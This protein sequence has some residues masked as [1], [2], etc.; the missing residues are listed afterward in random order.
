MKKGI[1]KTISLITVLTLIFQML[2]PIIPELN[3]EVLAAN[4]TSEN[5]EEISRN[6]EIKEEET[7]DISANGDG[8]IIAKWTRENR[9]LTISGTGKM[10]DWDINV[11]EDWHNTQYTKAIENVII[12]DGVTNIGKYAFYGC[13][14]LKS[15][16]IPEGVTSI[17]GSAFWGCSS[18][19]SINIP[20][21][22]TSIEWQAFR[23]C[24]SLESINIPEGVTSIG[25][26]AFYECSSLESINI[27]EGVTHI[28]YDAFFKCSKLEN[29]NV[30]SD[31]KSYISV[32]GILFNKEKTKLIKYPA[33]KN[34]VKEYIIPNTV[35]EIY[36]YAFEECSSL[37]SI[38]I[39]ERV[40]S[41]EECAFYKCNN[42]ESIN[43]PEGVTSIEGSAFYGCSSLESIKIPEGVISIEGSAFSR[44][45]SLE[46]INIPEG[47]TSIEG[48]AFYGCDSLK[49]INIPE[50]V[51]SIGSDAI[52][53]STIIYVKAD[54][55][56][57]RWVEEN[58]Q[59]YILNGD[60]V[61]I[62]TNYEIKEEEM[63]DI[64]ENGDGSVIAKWT[65]KDRTLTISGTGKIR[66]WDSSSKEDWHN[67]Q[68]TN[69]IESVVICEGITN[70]GDYAFDQCSNLKNIEIA[71]DVTRIGYVVF[72]GCSSL[73][74][75][76]IPEGVTSIEGY[77]F[78][79]CDSLKSINIPESITRIGSEAFSGCSKLENI[80][81]PEGL[82]EIDRSAFSWCDSLKNIKIPEEVMYIGGSPFRGCSSLENIDVQDGNKNY[83]SENGVLF[84]KERT[85][86]ICYPMGKKNIKEY[87][88]PEG[89]TSI[90]E[91]AFFGC[92]DLESINIPKGI[93]SIGESAFWRC[94]SLKSINIPKEVTSIEWQA[95]RGCSGLESINIPEG[96]T[97]IGNYAFYECSSLESI[98]I[99]EGVT[100]IGNYAFY[101]CSSLESINIPEGIT[102]IGSNAITSKA[103]IYTK[104]NK[105]AHRYAEESK[106]GYIIDDTGPT[107]TITPNSGENV[108]REYIAKVEVQ[109]DLKEVGVN[110]S[111]L[112]YQ[113]TQSE[114][115]PAKESFTES[116]ENGQ[117]ITKNTGDGK[118]YLWVYAEDNLGNETITRS[119]EFNF[120]NT[121]PNVNVEYSTKNPTKE[122]VK[123]TITSNEEVQELEGW[124]LSTNKKIL[125]KEY[126]E[127]TKEIVTVKDLA[128]NETQVNIEITN[129]DKTLPDIIIGDINN[130]T[131]V[132]ITDLFLLKRHIIAGSREA[133]KLTGD[134]LLAADMNEDGMVDITDL[135]MLKREVLNNIW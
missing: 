109:D 56:G 92:S 119:E 135:L 34:D 86:I 9:T 46:S 62:S 49:S 16:N 75:I 99:P 133:W 72:Q 22:V 63:W 10:K 79:G 95:F 51:T 129:I 44:C 88:I 30:S 33:K 61:E 70:I 103:V 36:S 87:L 52:P 57:H 130:D 27:P 6:Y 48:Y 132:D 18:L 50:G 113:W 90:R 85:E 123:V 100:S 68:Y 65:L 8:S 106:H 116:F 1:G 124:T 37:E 11:K 105:E 81:L 127:N 19:K 118:W 128:G 5:T 17:G 94:S 120:D 67:T 83:M 134:S 21:E 20:K 7:W 74:S 35:I 101:E 73:E 125:T 110:E 43:I 64:S 40:T 107:I 80:I 23:R 115:Q 31:N 108:Q 91:Y 111:K 60:A 96:V 121:A 77:A 45:S 102:S 53:L 14:S 54:S 4:E 59:G 58:E 76:N 98:N 47:V 41:I 104:S 71:E 26:Y 38:N 55:E 93:T 2:I 131:K 29:I 25:S 12:N 114:E 32:N 112:K 42:L 66:N 28:E 126:T 97:S 117:T 39:P 82:I 13:D 3:L 84:N 69:A 122:N 24:S 78:Y 89:V 15:I